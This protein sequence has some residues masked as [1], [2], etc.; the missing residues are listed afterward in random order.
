MRSFF[1]LFKPEHGELGR[2]AIDT[3]GHFQADQSAQL[4]PFREAATF[5]RA[6]K[7]ASL[8]SREKSNKSPSNRQQQSD[9]TVLDCSGCWARYS[10]CKTPPGK[11]I[12][13]M[14]NFRI[15]A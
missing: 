14:N 3:F 12:K 9:K 15:K 7:S 2:K 13:L 11:L 4:S 1:V 8:K 6:R 10:H 5:G